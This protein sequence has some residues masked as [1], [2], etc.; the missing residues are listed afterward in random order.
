MKTKS[1]NT[2]TDSAID[3]L[4][5]LGNNIRLARKLRG[6]T[7]EA[8]AERCFITPPTLDKLEKGDPSV[9]LY[10]LMSV[11]SIL[12]DEESI[13]NLASHERDLIGQSAA[14]NIKIIK[15]RGLDNDF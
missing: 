7:R 13:K 11:L 15:K 5:I 12:E 8:F 14:K 3:S 9:G 4:I 10:A 6:E 2:L 1:I